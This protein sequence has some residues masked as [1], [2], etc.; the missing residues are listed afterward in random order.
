MK[1]FPSRGFI[2]WP[3]GTGDS[4]TIVV[5]QKEGV[6]LQIDLRHMECANEKDDPHAPI[7][8]ILKQ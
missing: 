3:V 1:G 4:T 2:F 5:D 8:D 7:I 6:V